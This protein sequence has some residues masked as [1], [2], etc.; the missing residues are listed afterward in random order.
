M[1]QE[2]HS[3]TVH[4]SS[5]ILPSPLFRS[6]EPTWLA[7]WRKLINTERRRDVFLTFY[8]FFFLMSRQGRVTV[9]PNAIFATRQT[10][11]SSFRLFFPCERLIDPRGSSSSSISSERERERRAILVE[12]GGGGGGG[13]IGR[14]Q[15]GR[16]DKLSNWR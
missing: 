12:N 6:A 4:R 8:F 15:K 5:G 11:S 3:F 16:R 9:H 7:P 13:E 10:S 1:H 2:L 14:G